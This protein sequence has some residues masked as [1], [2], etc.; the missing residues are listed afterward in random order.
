MPDEQRMW[1]YS[2]ILFLYGHV[3]P[4]I[5]GRTVEFWED[6]ITS[7]SHYRKNWYLSM[8]GL[9]LTHVNKMESPCDIAH[10]ASIAN[11]TTDQMKDSNRDIIG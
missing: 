7:I 6:V 10:I 5:N 3:F 1:Q 2:P 9:K 11:E 4:K 8:L